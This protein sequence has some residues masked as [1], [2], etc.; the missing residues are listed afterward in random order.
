MS[1]MLRRS[2]DINEI[3]SVEGKLYRMSAVARGFFEGYIFY[4]EEGNVIEEFMPIDNEGTVDDMYETDHHVVFVGK[5]IKAR[6]T[7]DEF[8]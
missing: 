2:D 1:W 5:H 6:F 7:F 8:G 3:I 4:D